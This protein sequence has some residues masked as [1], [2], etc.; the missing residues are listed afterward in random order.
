MLVKH[1]TRATMSIENSNIV[2]QC[3]RLFRICSSP[4]AIFFSKQHIGTLIIPITHFHYC[5]SEQNNKKKNTFIHD[6]GRF[7]PFKLSS[8]QF[9]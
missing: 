6:Q 1:S 8:M 9:L 7:S 5:V 4:K 3:Y 2:V